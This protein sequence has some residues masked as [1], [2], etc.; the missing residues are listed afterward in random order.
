MKKRIVRIMGWV[1]ALSLVLGVGAAV[2]AGI[3]YAT[4]RDS[5]SVSFTFPSGGEELFGSEPGI[6][7]AA[8]VSGGPADEAGVVRGDI[9]LRVDGETVDDVVG[10]MRALKE[11]EV[12]DEV[13]LTV[14]H[15]DDERTLT[16]TLGDRDDV[17]Y[18]GLVPCASIPVS[19]LRLTVHTAH[20][21]PVILDVT[22]DSPAD[23][24][25]LQAGDVIVA[26]DGQ[27]ITGESN[28][29]D[30]IA[31]YEPGDTVILQV[32]RPGEESAEVA[33]EL[34][35]HPD[36]EGVAYLGVRYRPSRFLR[37][38]LGEGV[39]FG[40]SH[41]GPFSQGEGRSFFHVAPYFLPPAIVEGELDGEIEHGAIVRRVDEDSPAEAAGLREGD[42][43]T[44]VEGDPLEDPQGLVDAIAERSPGDR[45]TLTVSR[46]DED[47]E[48]EVEVI[49]AQD[50][51][52]EGKAYLGV[53][54]RGFVHVRHSEDGE[55]YEF[56]LD[57]EAPFDELP[58]EF[59]FSPWHFDDGDTSCL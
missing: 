8:V 28:L 26:V 32:E 59:H 39:P 1:T 3:V 14:L 51:E 55:E 19:D 40:W 29:A 12:G 18:L 44:A 27:E 24:A 33:V 47:E 2:G 36:E 49:L 52:E 5:D 58:F 37:V 53:W 21:G 48:R 45:V 13:E 22:P 7:V 43:I 17:A 57:L 6:V 34:G 35:E 10:L 56:E 11:H 15:G 46:L 20:P 31:A 4:T 38:P 25:G 42:L 16:A 41:G 54:I 9:L 23:Q 30:L 50:P